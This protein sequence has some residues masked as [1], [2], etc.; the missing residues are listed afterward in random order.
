MNFV[1]NF[2]ECDLCES[3]LSETKLLQVHIRAYHKALIATEP[4]VILKCKTPNPNFSKDQHFSEQNCNEYVKKCPRVFV[5]R[6]IL[7]ADYKII[8]A[9]DSNPAKTSTFSSTEQ[10][11]FNYTKCKHSAQNITFRCT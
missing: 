5:G 10:K 6:V 11:G 2:S 3:D 7:A 4:S 9:M 8:C 1:V